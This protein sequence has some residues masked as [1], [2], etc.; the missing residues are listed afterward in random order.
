MKKINNILINKYWE[1][2][3]IVYEKQSDFAN[4]VIKRLKIKKTLCC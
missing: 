3:M 2:I 4:F 1:N